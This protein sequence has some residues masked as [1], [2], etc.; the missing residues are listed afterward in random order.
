MSGFLSGWLHDKPLEECCRLGNAC[1]AI[2]V[3]RHGCAPAIPT[4]DELDWFLENG[5]PHLALRKDAALEHIHWATTR[6]ALERDL[7]VFAIDHRSQL[8][9]IA[10]DAAAP[11]EKISE[12]KS[13]ALNAID[14][15][16]ASDVDLGI[17]LDGRYGTRAL[18]SASDLPIWVGRAI[19]LPGSRPLDFDTQATVTGE[20]LEWTKSHV[21]KCLCF[22]HPGD[23]E[24]LKRLQERRI[25]EAFKASRESQREFLLEII[26]SRHGA[27]DDTTVSSAIQRIYDIGVFPDW[28]KLE[29]TASQQGWVETSRVIEKMDPRCRGI[30][31]LG[32]AAPAEDVVA[33]FKVA[34]AFPLIKGFAVGRT[35]FQEPA[36]QWFK[37]EI[38]DGEAVFALRRNFSQLIDGWRQARQAP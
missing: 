12:F 21:A 22:Y 8:E 6:G 13:L 34:A 24:E 4:A 38:D 5:S 1:G 31:L 17:L 16:D 32:L 20:M 23:P 19:E 18:E 26:C 7:A 10:R 29:A 14:M 30:L 37:G 3:S 11:L 33:C 25:L 9:T 2:V 36:R 15:I 28:W 35:I 27:L